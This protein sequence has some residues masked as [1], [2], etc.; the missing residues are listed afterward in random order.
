MSQTA[1]PTAGGSPLAVY[2][3]I[4]FC[5]RKCHYCDFFSVLYAPAVADHYLAALHRELELAAADPRFAGHPVSSV[6][7]GGGTPSVLPPAAL[8]RLLERLARSF[9][10]MSSVEITLEANPGTVDGPALADLR[11]AGYNRLSLGIQ[12][13]HDEF[14]RVL[15]RIHDRRTALASVEAARRAGFANLNLDLMHGLPGQTPDQWAADLDQA[16]ALAP[17]H[18]SAYGLAVEEATPFARWAEE[19]SLPLPDE[20]TART[21]LLM[22][23]DRLPQAGYQ[24]YETSNYARPGYRCQHN[25]AYWENRDYLGLGAG[26]WSHVAGQ[27]WG[28]LRDLEEY[29]R[30]VAADQLPQGEIHHLDARTELVETVL[31]GLRLLDGVD[32]EAFAV[33]FGRTMNDCFPGKLEALSRQGLLESDGRRWRLT[34]TAWPVANQVW[35]AFVYP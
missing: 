16:I 15:G 12:S 1:S 6:F 10:L 22:A 14:L 29:A 13:F 11:A 19:G 30:R 2:V 26:A 27:R 35:A 18:V 7:V 8:A 9:S 20:E 25:L 4:P 32:Q 31:M 5:L 21:M 28:N 17:D 3:H 24:H 23:M 34:R 33:R